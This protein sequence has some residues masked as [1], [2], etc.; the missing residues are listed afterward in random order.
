METKLEDKPG[1]CSHGSDIYRPKLHVSWS[2]PQSGWNKE[3]RSSE[4]ESV[5]RLEGLPTNG[6]PLQ[7]DQHVLVCW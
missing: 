3:G 1:K 6:K 5:H 4:T 2:L 7:T